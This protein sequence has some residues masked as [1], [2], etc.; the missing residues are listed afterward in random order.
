MGFLLSGPRALPTK[1]IAINIGLGPANNRS[2]ASP[3]IRVSDSLT[4]D[5]PQLKCIYL[6]GTSNPSPPWQ[7]AGLGLRLALDVGIHRRQRPEDGSLLETELWKRA[8]W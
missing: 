4:T 1:S 6:Q 8:F 2:N 7:M 5:P 3:K